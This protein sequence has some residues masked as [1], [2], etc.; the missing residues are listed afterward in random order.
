MKTSRIILNTLAMTSLTLGGMAFADEITKEGYLTDT[1]G[2]VVKSGVGLCWHTSSWAPA[3]A[4]Q[5][6][7]PD[8][9]KKVEPKMAE[10][11]KTDFAPKPVAAAPALTP[12]PLV[13]KKKMVFSADSSAD[14]LFGFDKS[15]VNPAGKQAIDKFIADLAGANFEVVTVIGH[16]DRIG[17]HAYNMKLST[18]RAEAVK[19]Y[20]VESSGIPANKI[21]AKGV[22]GT[23]PVT[24]PS[25]CKG[26]KATKKLIACLA[27]DRRVEVEV[28]ATRTYK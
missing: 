2:N 6:C 11:K 5:E 17:S 12:T 23:D 21:E 14:S 1:R 22:N 7:D 3:K 10:A 9:V 24:K 4:I 8:L 26:K 18:Q 25:E 28:V 27:P 19:A 13:I 15:T 20:M 16:T